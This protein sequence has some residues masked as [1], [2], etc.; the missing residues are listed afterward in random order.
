M[1]GRQKIWRIVALSWVFRIPLLGH[2]VK[3]EARSGRVGAVCWIKK[4]MEGKKKSISPLVPTENSLKRYHGNLA[5]KNISHSLES[6]VI[7][8]LVLYLE[9]Q[10]VLLKDLEGSK[11]QT[12][13][14]N[15][16]STEHISRGPRGD[17]ERLQLTGI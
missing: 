6:Y 17:A 11:V 13:L 1:L 10:L 5:V 14:C 16:N 3:I 9:D 15:R 12:T 4:L 7:F 2:T 8:P